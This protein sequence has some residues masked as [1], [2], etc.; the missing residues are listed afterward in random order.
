LSSSFTAPINPGQPTQ[1]I[2]ETRSGTHHQ[3]PTSSSS[4]EFC[5]VYEIES[6]FTAKVEAQFAKLIETATAQK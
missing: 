5:D 2:L 1:K 3:G 4:A 6:D